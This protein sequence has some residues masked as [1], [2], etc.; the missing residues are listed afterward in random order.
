MYLTLLETLKKTTYVL[1]TQFPV[2]AS[3][4]DTGKYDCN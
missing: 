3:K 2:F 4:L 1:I